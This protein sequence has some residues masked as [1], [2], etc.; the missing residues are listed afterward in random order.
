MTRFAK[1]FTVVSLALASACSSSEQVGG[2]AVPTSAP[3][4]VRTISFQRA[5]LDRL[6]LVVEPAGGTGDVQHLFF[7]GTLDYALDRYSEVGTLVEGRVASVRVNAGERV[8]K[9]DLLAEVAVPALVE[10]QAQ[11]LTAEAGSRIAAAHARRESDLLER[12]LTTARES[13]LARGDMERSMAE[14]AAAKSRV[15]LLSG[16]ATS[17]NGY[18]ALRAPIDGVVMDRKVVLGGRLPSSHT[19]FVIADLSVLWANVDVFES[20]LRHVK[21][22][23]ETELVVDAYPSQTFRGRVA[24]I[25]PHVAASR[26]ARA[27]IVVNNEEGLLKP[28]LFFRASVELRGLDAQQGILVPSLAVQPLGDDD[29]V[30]VERGPGEFEIRKVRL[31]RKTPQTIVVTEGLRKDERIVVRGASLLRS[32]ATKQ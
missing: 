12:S 11:L 29:V 2:S 18:L 9:G 31:G 8:K 17:P 10:A 30:F 32:E 22:G 27:R 24:V 16:G 6:G 13:E 14:L 5:T 28:G 3:P 4:P 25:E 7:P 23:S 1:L 15:A 21:A 19:A 26:S 20:D